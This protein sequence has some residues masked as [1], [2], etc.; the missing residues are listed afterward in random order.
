MDRSERWKVSRGTEHHPRCS[1]L[2]AIMRPRWRRTPR[3]LFSLRSLKSKRND[4]LDD[5]ISATNAMLLCT[6][7][8]ASVRE[9]PKR[10]WP[11]P[12]IAN[13]LLADSSAVCPVPLLPPPPLFLFF[14]TAMATNVEA[15][16]LLTNEYGILEKEKHGDLLTPPSPPAS[17]S[18]SPLLPQCPP[19]HAHVP[20]LRHLLGPSW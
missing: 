17:S 6:L 5:T 12:P 7:G 19:S 16:L 9:N 8:A 10:G 3:L 20:S 11:K 13:A 2:P 14:R 15:K 4:L 18:P 1:S